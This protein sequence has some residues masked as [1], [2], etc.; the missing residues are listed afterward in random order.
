MKK[1]VLLIDA[2]INF[3]LGVLL[4]LFSKPLAGFLGMPYSDVYFYPNILG[5]VL[6]GIAIALVI[7]Y[8][9]K[10]DG[11]VGLGLGGAVAINLCGGLVLAFWLILGD[12]NIT[13]KGNTF[14]WLLVIILLVI[15]SV[16]LIVHKKK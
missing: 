11:L 1:K 16:E 7:E 15:S 13:P 5:A 3:L 2:L 10:A 8:R 14:L 4:L 9:R 6:V 12:L